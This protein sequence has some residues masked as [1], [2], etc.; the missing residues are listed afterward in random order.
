MP[1]TP[2]SAIT[3]STTKRQ[4]YETGCTVDSAGRQ[5]VELQGLKR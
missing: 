3:S 1:S 4:H 2:S 5:D